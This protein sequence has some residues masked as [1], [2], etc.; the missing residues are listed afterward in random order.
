M[1]SDP[2][3]EFGVRL[4]R[5]R[6]AKGWSLAALARRSNVSKP[7]L[8][9]LERGSRRPSPTVAQAVDAALGADGALAAL[10]ADGRHDHDHHCCD[11]TRCD[12]HLHDRRREPALAADEAEL[13]LELY[14]RL[15]ADLRALGQTGSSDLLLPSLRAGATTLASAAAR[16]DGQVANDLWLLAAR[17]AEYAGWMAQ[18]RGADAA[19][20]AWTED[21]A[22][23]ATNA[24]D[25]DMV[26]YA[27]ERRALLALYRGDAAETVALARRAGAEPKVS[28]R[29]RAL[30]ARREAQ[31][32]ARAGDYDACYRALAQAELL[33]ADAPAPFPAGA[34]WGPNSIPDD[35]RLV[36]GWCLADL[37]RP[38]RAA[39]LLAAE[40]A[41]VPAG[42]PNTRT[43]FVVRRA[44][45]L[46]RAEAVGEACAVLAEAVP[47]VARADS[48]TIRSDVREVASTL[49]R[50]R[51]QP[52]VRAL[53]PDLEAVLRG[54]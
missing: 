15:F 38:A 50:Y 54:R 28:A 14:R 12:Q 26:G 8:S 2:R 46:A 9:S 4:R 42:C 51:R 24:G 20:A 31:G 16:C 7:H 11:Q 34:S 23:W 47:A 49:G 36:E 22:R 1:E 32:H 37:G 18:E 5:L 30:A 41:R 13:H 3:H 40:V 29:V 48:A 45:A 10:V 53:L 25:A 33:F 52:A 17:Y 6:A 43:R 39:E 35:S 21:A 44:L 19:S 27:W